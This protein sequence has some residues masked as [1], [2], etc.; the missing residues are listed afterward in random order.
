M[1]DFTPGQH[2][3]PD[4]LL[5][6]ERLY[7]REREIETL[8]TAFDRVV[9]GGRPELVLVSGYSGI[10]KSAVVNELHKPLVPPRGLF[11]SGKF[12]QYKRDI[13][14]ATLAQAF[15]SL[16]R[17]LLSQ[18]EEELNKWRNALHEALDPNGQLMVGLVPELKAIIG[19][20]LPVPELPQQDAQRRFHIVFRRFINV[21]AQPEHPLALFLDD[22]Q[23]LD[24]A[25][26]DLVEDL[27]TQQ[28]MKHLMLIG[29]YR[30]NEVDSTHPLMR[31]LEAMRQA[32]TLLR[33][34]VLAPLTRADLEQLIADSLHC[35][36]GHARPLAEL[37]HDKTTGNPFFAIQFVS[38]LF[39][40]GLL[41]FDHV[42]GRWSWD[43]NLIHA[44]RYTD[45]VVDLMVG[46]LA[47]LASETQNALKQLA[48]LGNSPEF[49][50]L[51]VVYQDSMDQM[52][53]QLAEAVGAGFILR[54]KT[55]YQF[56]HDR[57]QE[58][59]YSLIPEEMRAEA[60]L[61]IG[62]SMS[63]HTPA[64]KIEEGIF[65]IVNQLN[66]G[67]YLVTSIA[68]C[69]SIAEL[70]LIAGRRAKNS[71]A[72]ASALMYLRA[73]RGLL[74]N[75]V[76]NRNYDLVFSIESLT[77]ECELLTTAMAAAENRL[78]MLAERAKG[79]HDIARVT[80]LRLTLYT[81]LDRSDRAVEV[82][83]EFSRG[84]GADWPAHPTDE[85][86]LREYDHI[87]SLLGTR[88]IEELV[89]LPLITNRDVLDVLDVLSE[90]VTPALW[91]DAGLHALVIFRMVSLSLEHG[92][93]DGSCYA[94]VWLGMFAGSHFGNYRDGFRFGKL[95]HDLVEQR[96][97]HRYQA[98]TYMD[99]A[100]LVMPWTKHIK[101][102]RELQRRCFDAANRIGD[103]TYAAYS[104]HVLI[105][106][107]L[108]AG[109][110]LAQVEREA[111]TGLEFTTNIRF[112]L[113]M[114]V[115]STQ[116]ALVRMLRG[117]TKRFGSFNEEGFD[118]LRFERH[119]ANDPVLVLPEC[120]Y[121]IRKLQARFIEGDYPSAIEASL[122]A[123]RLL[124]KSPFPF[125]VAEYHFY[126]ALSR[127]ASFDSATD[128]TRQQQCE[129]LAAHQ[130]QHEVWAQHC[131]ENFENRAALVGA[132]IARIEGRMLKAEQLYEQAIRSAHSNGFIHNEAIAY[133]LAA[134]FYA[135]RGLQKFAAA[136]LLEAR[137]CYQRW[138]ADGKVAQLDRLYPHLIK[139]S[140]LS[141]PTSTFLS[142]T[143]LLD[144]N[145]VIKVSQ[146]V[147]GEMVLEK[148]VDSLMRAAIEHAGAERGLLILPRGDHLQI[149][150]E[151]TTGEN[152]VTVRQGDGA[153]S[154]A[155]MPESIVRYAMRTQENVILEDA[156]SQNPF[157]ADPYIAQRRPRSILTLPLVNQGKLISILHLENNLAAH[158]FTPDR[159][160][161]LKVLASQAA[162]S[163][164][165]TRLYR[166]LEDRERKIGRLI[167][168]NI[169]GI[170]IWDMDGRLIDANDAFLRMVRYE[171]EDLLAG[172]RWFDMTPPEWQE[173]HARQEA[174]ELQATG[175]MQ[176][177][178]KEYFRK[179]GT[180]VPVLIGA[181]CF[182]GQSNQGVAYILDLSEQKRA[183]EALR[184][185][186]T[187]L[188]EAQSLTHT[189]S[190]A[191]DGT[192]HQ[193]VYWSDE[194]FRLFGFDP[195]QGLPMFEQWLQRIHPEDRERLTLA[196][197]RTFREKVNCDVEFRIVKPDG[198]VKHIHGIGHPV[199]SPTG[200]LIQVVGTMVDVTERKRAEAERERLRR[201]QADLAH[202]NR[203]ATMGE[204]TATLA[205]EIKQPIGAAV[206][207]AEACLRL[208][209]RPEPDLPEARE[210]ALEMIKDA[211]RAANIIDRVRLLYQK[212]SSQLETVDL[213]QVIEEMVTMMGHEANR[214]AVAIRTDLAHGLP[215]VMADRVQLQQALMNLM[216]NGIE[217][218]QDTGGELTVR[219]Q[220]A[221]D[222]RL[223]VSVIDTGVGL[224][225]E[226]LDKMF[227]AFF[228]TKT[229]G[230]GLGLAIT[231]SI[232]QSHGGNIWAAPNSGAG[233]T[234]H[235]A[236]PAGETGA[237]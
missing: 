71:T 90:V 80:R 236:L 59:A 197:E 231:R 110:P 170:V 138:G 63:S 228:T 65:E 175:M 103:L 131:P 130:K 33:D 48:C 45:N 232:A 73:G 148:L 91:T 220:L 67:R 217:A 127:A 107:L 52:H 98:R 159:I 115:V 139:E 207:N 61:R 141:A 208:I 76:W 132:E 56:L 35:E 166:D 7:G 46:K 1:A 55:S 196:N 140:Q 152:D 201:A 150:A 205:H 142:P 173:V 182:E 145:T 218:M 128:N 93:C 89:D 2:D 192:S 64:D 188:V 24:A 21:F 171:R 237:A 121:W 174:E 62:M 229:Q 9:A 8:L 42:E 70:N 25:T 151:A 180:R 18:R 43:L 12:D 95:G 221:A 5:V 44:K 144:L 32:G 206:T 230:T 189:G 233:A 118:E 154:R 216:L 203:V 3:I 72:Y 198:T 119:L 106:N 15:Q 13:P 204:L 193:T 194:M 92:N 22:L 223:L 167:D 4:R 75:E 179:D 165:N 38:A 108:A 114:D 6:P 172:L 26:L 137:Y 183:E 185:S 143:E 202:I 50:V 169:I 156:S 222:G 96:G 79:A 227:N 129:A 81:A 68:E 112:G 163:L 69:E 60:H 20:Q 153:D 105:T 87:W 164:E 17:P 136:Y 97:L 58:A 235:F 101:A 111:E 155:A 31:K 122:N 120:W 88:Q 41:T 186:E 77:A 209:D 226:N 181:A 200:E 184:R 86:V 123:E 234:F 102:G 225:V 54:S 178:E 212:G 99:F 11:A 109:D 39:E 74:T 160:T 29:A 53:A 27:L 94:Y 211:R 36:P 34:I 224:P 40:E 213:N 147:S 116:R 125:E 14:Y 104:F 135:G 66:R 84:R 78:S 126:S 28:D 219:S 176:A 199:L 214:H 146:A 158:V 16:I 30:D 157:S 187:Y 133:E 19:E 134:R 57:V 162:I 177:R 190:C 215:T 83:L 49:T 113:M 168:S 82:F 37:V 100:T 191:I 51:S 47:R 210:A 124:G 161:V 23:W 149:A 195:Q 117:V 10:G 85:E